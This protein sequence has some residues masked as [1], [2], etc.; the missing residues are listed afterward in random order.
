[1]GEAA[2]LSRMQFPANDMLV[3]AFTGKAIGF[4]IACQY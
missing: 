1:M 2:R 3:V 4:T